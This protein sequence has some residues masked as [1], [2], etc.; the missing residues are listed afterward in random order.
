MQRLLGRRGSG[1][2]CQAEVT[3]SSEVRMILVYRLWLKS[4]DVILV[5]S[6]EKVLCE[7]DP[8]KDHL[9]Y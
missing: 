5:L 8:S 9:V 3:A 6:T 1:E 2:V 4:T 7:S